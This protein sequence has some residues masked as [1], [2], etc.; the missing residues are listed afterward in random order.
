VV[1]PDHPGN[2]IADFEMLG[3]DAATAQSAIDR[4]LDVAF[5]LDWAIAGDAGVEVDPERIGATGHSF[6]GWTV[7][8]AARDDARVG[9]IAPLAPGFQNGA[10]PDFVAELARPLAIFGGSVD[11]TT[12]FATDQQVPYDVAQPP[13][14]LV[15]IVGAGHLDFSNLCEVMLLAAFVDDGCDPMSI[16]PAD[17]HQRVLAV[18]T[19]F[20]RR[21]LDG[22]VRYDEFLTT[23]AVE[24]LGK[25]E[26]WHEP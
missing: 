14:A 18:A 15:Q 1:A 22:D 11:A 3:D 16:E 19:A 17:V 26:Y 20:L 5:V 24:G 9:V 13:K 10:T 8:E 25:L 6:G 7:L 23:T 2:T 12:P 21:H 4:P